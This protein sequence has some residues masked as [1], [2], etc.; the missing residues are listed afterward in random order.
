MPAAKEKREERS[1]PVNLWFL[2]DVSI[3]YCHMSVSG[4]YSEL[5]Q[6]HNYPQ[7]THDSFVFFKEFDKRK[8]GCQPRRKNGRNALILSTEILNLWFLF[9][10]SI[11][12]SHMSVS[13]TCFELAQVHNYLQLALPDAFGIFFFN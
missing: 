12:Y 10:F 4:A 8:Q 1:H 2:L 13:G 9:H 5:S 3:I 11:S 6:V 7:L